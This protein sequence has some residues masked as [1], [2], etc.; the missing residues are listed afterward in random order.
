MAEGVFEGGADDVFKHSYEVGGYS[1]HTADEAFMRAKGFSE[2]R[3]AAMKEA[4]MHRAVAEGLEPGSYRFADMSRYIQA[5][6]LDKPL[7][8]ARTA[9]IEDLDDFI[10]KLEERAVPSNQRA[11]TRRLKEAGL[12]ERSA[13]WDDA[14]EYLSDTATAEGVW[15]GYKLVSGVFKG[16]KA[17]NYEKKVAAIRAR[18]AGLESVDLSP[19]MLEP[20]KPKHFTELWHDDV[21]LQ[22]G[23]T[24][25]DPHDHSAYRTTVGPTDRRAERIRQL[26]PDGRRFNED[27]LMREAATFDPHAVARAMHRPFDQ[28]IDHA[29]SLRV[30]QH[31]YNLIAEDGMVSRDLLMGNQHAGIIRPAQVGRN[32][33]ALH[34][35]DGEIRLRADVAQN[36][37]LYLEGRR[38]SAA[39]SAMRTVVHETLHSA[40]PCPSFLYSTAFDAIRKLEEVTTET[41]ARRLVERAIGRKLRS[42]E[43]SYQRWIDEELEGIKV[44]VNRLMRDKGVTATFTKDEVEGWVQQAAIDMRR[45]RV[46]EKPLAESATDY[47]DRY[48]RGFP[49]P[50]QVRAA[51]LEDEFRSAVR[52]GRY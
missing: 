10:Y 31:I 50:D 36:F 13:D 32:T 19:A 52:G 1:F 28:R 37:Q 2:A 20:P 16:W 5:N 7:V 4:M 47:M 30:R 14:L 3:E 42:V 43:V 45:Y 39:I 26:Y 44:R 22:P 11:I 9:L 24:Y 21:P 6:D 38:S 27:D 18:L 46:G 17:E 25:Y 15:D 23:A 12:I 51:G 48:V 34:T 49:V 33:R 29:A 8:E 35:W 40:S 41:G